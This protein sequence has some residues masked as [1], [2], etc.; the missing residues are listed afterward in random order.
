MTEELPHDYVEIRG[1]RESHVL[2]K[3]L[4]K[5][6]I[7]F[8]EYLLNGKIPGVLRLKKSEYT[9]EKV[10]ELALEREKTKHPDIGEVVRG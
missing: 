9:K 2:R 4:T 1:I 3:D 10:L 5:E 7:Y 8:V 6:E